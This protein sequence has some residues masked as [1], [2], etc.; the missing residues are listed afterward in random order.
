[1]LKKLSH[2]VVLL[3]S[4]SIINSC[5]FE[6]FQEDPNRTTDATPGLLLTNLIVNSFNT[7]DVTPMLTSRMLVYTDGLD[8]NQ[9]YGWNRSGF[10]PYGQLRQ[11]FKM[12]E[13]AE[14][15]ELPNYIA[16]AKFFRAYHFYQLTMTFGEI[17]YSEALGGFND[18]YQPAYDEQETVFAGILQDLEEA[19]QEL[20]VNGSP[21]LGD[22]LFDGSLIKWKRAINSFRLRVLMAL[23]QKDG[24]SSIDV[25]GQFQM[26]ANNPSVYP[27]MQSNDDN[28]A[29]RYFDVAGNRYPYF[30]N[31]NLTAAY[32]MEQTF[33]NF[34]KDNEDPRL[35]KIA[36]I[37]DQAA[38]QGLDPSDFEAYGGLDGAV[39]FDELNEQRAAGIGSL[40]N[41]RYY[42]DPV[43]EPGVVMG[44]AELQFIL[45]EAAVR[46]WI[47]NDPEGFY[48]AGILANMAF[49]GVDNTEANNY[50]N[51]SF[52]SFNLNNAIEQ[53]STQRYL[54]YFFSGGWESYYNQRRV[55]Y[56][57][58]STGAG[59]LNGDKVPVR[60]LYPEQES[61]LNLE[62]L[63]ASLQR[64]FGGEDSINGIM[65]LLN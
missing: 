63:E 10:G 13:E 55:G 61:N 47:G 42:T 48:N 56:P 7:V 46:G 58:F 1:M 26:V 40:V 62:N 14:E 38:E 11:V 15:A 60:W 39:T 57:E 34:M 12:I 31:Q 51:G 9:Y 17:P 33:V 16:L 18:N 65:W 50:L 41:S 52:A 37:T 8:L 2:I 43:G 27:L 59:T 35:F 22:V 3:L 29:L 64:Q 45:A 53:I 20:N 19:N 21:L 24:R 36:S 44:Y 32:L 28:L 49:Y 4:V 25:S 5:D 23:S 6:E 30:E 54:T